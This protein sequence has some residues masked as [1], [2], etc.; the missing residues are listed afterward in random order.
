MG[1]CYYA[2]GSVGDAHETLCEAIGGVGAIAEVTCLA[3]GRH[4]ECQLV[5]MQVV[6]V[7]SVVVRLTPCFKCPM[8]AVDEQ[9]CAVS[10]CVGYLA[11]V[12]TPVGEMRHGGWDVA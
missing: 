11:G 9:I 1:R 2:Y 6:D 12:S 7:P 8:V 5:V 4:Y 3:V 10:D